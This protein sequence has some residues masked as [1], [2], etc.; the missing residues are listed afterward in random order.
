LK[1]FNHPEGYVD[2]SGSGYEYVYQY[3]DHL[4]N[5]RLAYKDINQNN[6]N[7]I[8]LQIQ[9]E[10]NYYPFG[11]K[12]KGYNTNI[13]GTDHKYGFGGKEEQD[14][15]GLE[16]M[17]FHA[18][19]Y[20]AAL[21]RW[22]NIDPL[23]QDYYEWSPY[24]YAFNS[25]MIFVDPTGLG[26]IYDKDGNLIGYEVEEGQG[27]TQIAKDLNTIGLQAEV[28]YLDIVNSNPEK[29]EHIED[30][31]DIN[32]EGFTEL[33]INAGDV[34]SV[35]TVI[36]R[37]NAITEDKEID[38][39]ISKTE[40]EM[41]KSIEAKDEF[42]KDAD[43][44]KKFWQKEVMNPA[45]RSDLGDPHV[46]RDLS[47]MLYLSPI[48]NKAKELKKKADSTKEVIKTQQQKINQLKNRKK[49]N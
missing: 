8:S 14:E 20:D 25:P 35:D 42:Q 12:H 39:E 31:N 26:P 16:W 43:S 5:V 38:S 24:N 9:E 27:P 28:N 19:N 21:G 47:R 6:A 33:D 40:T 11:L 36:D 41:E 32:D 17:D 10:N 49:K 1:F 48:E 7:P 2:A 30:V 44:V 45:Y 23:A 4:G 37:E 3:K 46:G 18:R 34:I 13:V 29:F 22:M 15:L